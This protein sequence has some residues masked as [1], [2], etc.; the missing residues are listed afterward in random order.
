MNDGVPL[1]AEQKEAAI[2]V[3]GYK[4]SP[5][6]R[7]LLEKDFSTTILTNNTLDFQIHHADP[8]KILNYHLEFSNIVEIKAKKSIESLTIFET[9]G[10]FFEFYNPLKLTTL[11]YLISRYF[12]AINPTSK[13]LAETWSEITKAIFDEEFIFPLFDSSRII[14]VKEGDVE[15]PVRQYIMTK[16]LESIKENGKEKQKEKKK[17]S[18]TEE[19]NDEQPSHDV[20]GI[21]DLDLMEKVKPCQA[22]FK[23]LE[24]ISGV[25]I[26]PTDVISLFILFKSDDFTSILKKS[27]GDIT[28]RK[29]VV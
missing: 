13:N 9:L 20:S 2:V 10:K 15:I 5:F 17:K 23:K 7:N 11:N 18:D 1:M 21:I 22:A 29:S 14:H 16:E 24:Q 27:S 3:A 8:S 12:T 26:V 25:I 4:I 28:D 19:K 6:I